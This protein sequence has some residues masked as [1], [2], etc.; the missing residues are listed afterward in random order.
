M[1]QQIADLWVLLWDAALLG[2]VAFALL[3][4]LAPLQDLFWT[5][6]DLDLPIGAATA[7]KV[8][9]FEVRRD[10]APEAVEAATEACIQTLSMAGIEV[11]RAPDRDDG[12]FCVVQ[13]AVRLKGGAMTPLVPEGLIMQ[14]PLALRH[15]LWDRHVI[16]PSAKEILGTQVTRIDTLGSYACRR[17]YGSTDVSQ[18]PSEHARANALDISGFGF[19][20]GSRVSV[21]SDWAGEGP[22]GRAG[23]EFLRAV[24]DGGC[25]LF[26]TV[27]TPDYNAAHADHLHLDGAP[28]R[29][30][31]KGP[32]RATSP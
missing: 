25:R 31:A 1:R 15:V 4:I 8:A 7:A 3:H 2:C 11:E 26:S 28:Y 32:L 17:I 30:C 9:D 5:P 6:L 21:V 13:G 24:R 16:S 10:D 27:L 23:A 18:R 19:E 14:C 29:L 22:A 12:G 20:D